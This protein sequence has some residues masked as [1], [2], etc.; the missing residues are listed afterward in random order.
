MKPFYIITTRFSND[1]W[2]ENKKWKERNKWE[3][4][5]YAVP[6][7]ISEYSGIPRDARVYVIE[8]NNDTNKIM[9]IGRIKNKKYAR[10]KIYK[11]GEYNRHIYKGSFRKDAS[12]FSPI[13]KELIDQ[14]EQI[15]FKGSSHMKR[16]SGISILRTEIYSHETLK[17]NGKIIITYLER[18]LKLAS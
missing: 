2:E 3:G 14:F 16:G 18:S 15:V 4:C 7:Q 10:E 12:K 5:I 1:T 17:D 11:S 6:S 13:E 9:G 8:M